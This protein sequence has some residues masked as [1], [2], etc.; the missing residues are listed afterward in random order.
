MP[1]KDLAVSLM[2]HV[3]EYAGIKIDRKKHNSILHKLVLLGAWVQVLGVAGGVFLLI[4]G[5]FW[6]KRRKSKR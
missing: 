4:G 3:K 1:N 2:V 5:I 6:Y